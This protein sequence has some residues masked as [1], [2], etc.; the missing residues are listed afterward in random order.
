MTDLVYILG[1]GSTWGN[2]E[3]RYSLRSVEKNLNINK[4]FVVGEKC[5]WFSDKIIHIP[6]DDPYEIKTRNAFHKLLIACNDKRISKDFILMNDDFFI[7]KKLDRIEYL[8]KGKLID[9]LKKHP[10]KSGYYFDALKD[11]ISYL[12]NQEALD[13]SLHYPFVYNKAKLKKLI[14]EIEKK[15]LIILLRAAY[16]NLNKVGGTY[17]HDIKATNN[18]QLK[19]IFKSSDVMSTTDRIVMF[20]LFRK[21]MKKTFQSKSIYEK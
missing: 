19:E 14:T 10:T 1:T 16:G 4:V 20:G 17:R 11:T 7:L 3:I 9:S 6:A 13:Y 2:N 12:K 21:Y 15:E 18:R 5:K 8:Y